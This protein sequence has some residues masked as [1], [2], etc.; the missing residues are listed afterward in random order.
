MFLILINATNEH[1]KRK[2]WQKNYFNSQTCKDNKNRKRGRLVSNIKKNSR[3]LTHSP[4]GDYPPFCRGWK[5][6]LTQDFTT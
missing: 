6:C 2:R 1:E 5:E 3:K 4:L